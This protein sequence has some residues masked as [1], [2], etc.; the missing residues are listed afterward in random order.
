MRKLLHCL[1]ISLLL[2]TTI[3]ALGEKKL[4]GIEVERSGD[5]KFSPLS[6]TRINSQNKFNVSVDPRIEL[7]SVIQLLSG[8]VV[9]ASLVNTDATTY[10]RDLDVYFAAHRGHLAVMIFAKIYP[11]GFRFDVPPKAM[12]YFSD[13]PELI[14]RQPVPDDIMQKAGGEEQFSQFINALRDFA[15]KT[16]F[17]KFYNAHRKNYQRMVE[18]MRERTKSIDL[19]GVLE[20]YYGMKQHSYNV[21]LM[22]LTIELGYGVNVQRSDETL[23]IYQMIGRSTVK[24]GSPVFGEGGTFTLQN[25]VWHEF[26]HSFVNPLTTKH[27]AEVLKYAS[28]YEPISQQM[29]AQA[30]P[31]WERAVNEHIIRALT[32]RFAAREINK[33]VGEKELQEDKKKGFIYIEP[34]IERLKEYENQRDK[35]RTFAEFYP[36]LIDVFRKIQESDSREKL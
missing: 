3:W 32:S 19:V 34:L 17:M 18:G 11:K 16:K 23:D 22:P 21:M 12:L 26:S 25:I 30:Y 2:Q 4:I 15:R 31:D 14:E 10:R 36:H 8:Y 6:S 33:E 27:K 7:L 35:Y 1:I 20:N 24:N 29:K 5:V 9:G 28:L 13:P